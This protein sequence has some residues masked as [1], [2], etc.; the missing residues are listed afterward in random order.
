M[1]N[2]E[3][4]M[5]DM[6]NLPEDVTT[7]ITDLTLFRFSQFYK[8][9]CDTESPIECDSKK[10]KRADASEIVP[11]KEEGPTRPKTSPMEKFLPSAAT[12]NDCTFVFNINKE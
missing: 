11:V 12:F 3:S 2:N 8:P 7:P 5:V 6:S 4:S 1:K 10:Q 9:T